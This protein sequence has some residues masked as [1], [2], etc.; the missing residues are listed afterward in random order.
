MASGKDG[1]AII[2]AKTETVQAVG[3]VVA[4][5]VGE[6]FSVRRQRSGRRT[7]RIGFVVCQCVRILEGEAPRKT[8]GDFYEERVIVRHR[9]VVAGQDF[10]EGRV[11]KVLLAECGSSSECCITCGIRA[12]LV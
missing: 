7:Q 11:A 4:R 9:S 10:G 3:A 8:P 12:Q 1:V 6:A 5:S 2:V